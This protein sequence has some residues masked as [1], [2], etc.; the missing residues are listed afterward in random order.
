MRLFGYWRRWNISFNDIK[1]AAQADLSTDYSQVI[2]NRVS[3]VIS[4]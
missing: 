3:K 1:T 2:H 4:R